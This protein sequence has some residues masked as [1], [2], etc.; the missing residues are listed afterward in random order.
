MQFDDVDSLEQIEALIERVRTLT[1]FPAPHITQQSAQDAYELVLADVGATLP[2]RDPV[3]ERI[4]E[5][6]R[7]GKVT[8]RRG[9]IKTPDDVGGWP[10][11]DSASAP[12]DSDHDGMPDQWE[13]KY[14]LEPDDF[15]DGSDDTDN[16]GYTNVEE[17]LN[18]TDPTK[19]IDYT[20]PKNNVNTLKGAS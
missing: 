2:R 20:D 8:F 17:W 15:F 12:I 6:V 10:Q 14:G 1:Q 16:D 7:T 3:D 18:G 11:Y 5:S 19:F 4:I 13:L 9:I